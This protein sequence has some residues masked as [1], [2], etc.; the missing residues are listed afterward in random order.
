MTS[1]PQKKQRC[2]KSRAEDVI[3]R[4]EEDIQWVD[5]MDLAD[6]V[7]V[8]HIRGRSY[9]AEKLKT[10]ASQIWGPFLVDI[11]TVQTFVRG[12]FALRFSRADHTSWVLSSFWHF[13]KASVLLKRWTPLFDPQLEQIGIGPVWVRLPGLP[14]QYWSEE[15][16]RRI[17]NTLGT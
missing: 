16:F 11:P 2:F 15:I 1:R 5:A 12:W 13:E 9:T 8:G 10:W 14:L 4:L 6:R 3:L 17:G 7:L